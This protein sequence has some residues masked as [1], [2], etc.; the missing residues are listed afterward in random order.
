[1]SWLHGLLAFL[2]LIGGSVIIALVLV[3]VLMI[4]H[5]AWNWFINHLGIHRAWYNLGYRHAVEG[6]G[7][8]FKEEPEEE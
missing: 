5:G 8:L 1:M 7:R 4:I 2:A 3:V 6:R